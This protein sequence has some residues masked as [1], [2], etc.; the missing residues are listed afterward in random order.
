MISLSLVSC[1]GDATEEENDN[2]VV[3]TYALDTES[4][5][6]RWTGDYFK[7]GEFDHNHEGF[8]MFNS[9]SIEVSDGNIL[10]GTFE[11]NMNTIDEPNAP[12]GEE[13]RMKFLGHLKSEDYFDVEKYPTATITLDK[14]TTSMLSGM[15][16]VKGVTMPFEAPV[17]TS[18][19]EDVMKISGDFKLNF[20]PFGMDGIGSESDPEFVSPNVA[21]SIALKLNKK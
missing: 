5:I 8:V 3:E 2:A 20:A 19:S 21:F 17:T 4:S 10:S 14:S 12:M 9:G 15:I 7:G 11:L 13:A 1:G 6:I 18:S 16:T